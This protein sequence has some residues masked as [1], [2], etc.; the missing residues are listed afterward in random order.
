MSRESS[1]SVPAEEADAGHWDAREKTAKR[2]EAMVRGED[3]LSEE[4]IQANNQRYRKT[5]CWHYRPSMGMIWLSLI[6][7]MAFVFS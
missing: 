5:S 2:L 6:T 1:S 4:Q 3:E 7:R